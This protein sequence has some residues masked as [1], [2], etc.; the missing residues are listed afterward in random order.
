MRVLVLYAH[1]VETSFNARVHEVVVQALTQ[2]GH[3]V[4]DCD[5]YAEG[6]DAVLSRQERL[7]Y[8]DLEI[9]R[10]PV[11]PYVER[12]LAAEALVL[13]HPIWNFGLPAI[14]KGF[15]DRVFLPG[16]SFHLKDGN[17]SPGLTHIT[18]LAHVV[19]YGSPR[20]RA[21]VL[22]DA[23]RK[24]ATRVMR[25]MTKPGAPVSYLAQYNMNKA[26]EAELKGHL[27]RVRLK[28]LAF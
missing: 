10:T 2:A 4:D 1:P 12:L 18:K 25:A 28:M 16:V 21:F 23:P 11:A 27:D 8:H 17:L 14:L 15:F 26:S 13:V 24:V 3:E 22:G 20:W 5:L 7:D 9:N 19:T 6:F